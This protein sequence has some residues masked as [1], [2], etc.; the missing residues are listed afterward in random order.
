MR[1]PEKWCTSLLLIYQKVPQSHE[2]V[3]LTLS[4]PVP[5]FQSVSDFLIKKNM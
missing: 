4:L 3:A 1:H 2:E 5:C